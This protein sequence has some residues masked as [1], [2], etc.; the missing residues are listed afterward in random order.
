MSQNSDDVNVSIGP[1][2][3]ITNHM[4]VNGFELSRF[5]SENP[6]S[7]FRRTMR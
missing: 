2:G 4:G 6:T 7:I 3:G 1:G 5:L